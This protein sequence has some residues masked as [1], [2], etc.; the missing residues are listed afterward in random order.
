MISSIVESRLLICI[1]C[2]FI[3]VETC[4]ACGCNLNNKTRD[5]NEQCPL[6][7][8]K[9]SS[10]PLVENTMRTYPVMT[11]NKITNSCNTCK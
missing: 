7:P 11:E 9:W 6:D 4:T 5:M 8:P 2:P 3:N 1:E 10:R